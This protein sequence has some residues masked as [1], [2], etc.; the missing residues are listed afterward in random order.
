MGIFAVRELY[1]EYEQ[2]PHYLISFKKDP[3][4]D[5]N[6]PETL[7]DAA[8]RIAKA[9]RFPHLWGRSH[10][11]AAGAAPGA[12]TNNYGANPSYGATAANYGEA[13]GRTPP[14]P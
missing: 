8:K 3:L 13:G 11:A 7:S 5:Q 6:G 4:F 2:G 1:T 10:P 9:I 14:R 12:S